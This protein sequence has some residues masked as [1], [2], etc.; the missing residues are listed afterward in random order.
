MEF[1]ALRNLE[2][3]GKRKATQDSF[4]QSPEQNAFVAEMEQ[5]TQPEAFWAGFL[6]KKI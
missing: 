4:P 3:S 6:E 5:L 2:Y 1:T